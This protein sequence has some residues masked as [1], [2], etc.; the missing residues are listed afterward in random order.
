MISK[1]KK[2]ISGKTTWKFVILLGIVS[3]FADMTYEGARSITGQFLT[4]LGASATIVGIF[5]GLGEFIGYGIRLVSGYFSDRTGKYWMITISGY[6]LNLLA[7][8]LLAFAGRWEIAVIL[9]ML[10]RMGKAIRN[11]ARDAMLS[12]ATKEIGRGKGF[13]FHEA[14]DQIGAMLGPLIV[15]SI[16]YFNKSYPMSFGILLIP[17]LLAII[18]LLTARR[19]YPHPRDLEVATA[20]L[21]AKGFSRQFWFY[22]AAASLVGAGY[23][24]F[25]LVAYHFKKVAIVSDPIIPIFYAVAMG[26]DALAALVLGYLYDR[27]G[28]KVLLGVVLLSSLF[29][30][31][32]FWGGFSLSLL[33][34]ILW[35]IGMG[36]QESILRAIIGGLVPVNKRGTAYGIFNAI[37]GLFW[38]LG[39]ALTGF[40]YDTS[41]Y[42]LIVFSVVIQVASIPLFYQANKPDKYLEGGD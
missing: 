8:P 18:V 5:A 41:L 40:L 23:V 21:V 6:L 24:D 10:E 28:S 38:F 33:G 29:S 20:G 37:F 1:S 25:P 15:A 9:M 34:M 14:M 36:A 4:V 16:F 11:P 22:V 7:V 39:S 32:V 26:V 3:L 13:G 19:L 12:H 42:Y 17:A 31:L 27:K 30:P 35:G 2:I